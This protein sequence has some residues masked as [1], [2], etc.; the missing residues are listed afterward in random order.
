M[1][2]LVVMAIAILVLIIVAMFFSGGFKRLGLSMVT[3]SES[4]AESGVAQ[5]QMVCNQRCAQI[6]LDDDA[7]TETCRCDKCGDKCCDGA[8]GDVGPCTGTAI[9][10][11]GETN[12]T[13]SYDC[14]E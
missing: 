11:Y 12:F 5:A 4:M 7:G 3:T 6:K 2:M 10:T 14:T 8:G 9:G 13:C 1:S